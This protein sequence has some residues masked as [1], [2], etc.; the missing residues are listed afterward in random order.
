MGPITAN[1]FPILTP[2]H[3]LVSC[4]QYFPCYGNSENDYL[5]FRILKKQNKLKMLQQH[6]QLPKMIFLFGILL[7]VSFCANL[8]WSLKLD[9]FF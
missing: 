1:K 2:K 5:M 4:L 7:K 6:I 3:Y 8:L 9:I